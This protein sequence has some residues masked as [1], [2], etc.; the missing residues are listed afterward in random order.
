MVSIAEL[1]YVICRLFFLIQ[2]KE[3]RGKNRNA[4]RT[5]RSK[6]VLKQSGVHKR[7]HRHMVC[8]MGLMPDLSDGGGGVTA[9]SV[10]HIQF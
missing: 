7:R 4:E 9:L 8:A 1:Q 3:K 10:C 6:L 5:K 2:R